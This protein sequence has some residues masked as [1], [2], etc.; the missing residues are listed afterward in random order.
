MDTSSLIQ[1]DISKFPYFKRQ[2]SKT[3]KATW[4]IEKLL[5]H[6]IYYWSHVYKTHN[7]KLLQAPHLKTSMWSTLPFLNIFL[8]LYFHNFS[9]TA[10]YTQLQSW[11]TTLLTSI[12]LRV[13]NAFLIPNGLSI[14][15][16]P[17]HN[18]STKRA[19]QLY[20]CKKGVTLFPLPPRT[21]YTCFLRNWS[22]SSPN[23]L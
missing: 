11:L 17:T 16:S 15:S 18:T 22:P 13:R 2:T 10:I 8:F 14:S 21:Y 4:S 9:T 3:N 1:E 7:T 20:K 6:T 23:S 5:Y 12:I 19:N